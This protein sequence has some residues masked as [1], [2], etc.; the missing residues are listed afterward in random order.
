MLL[1]AACNVTPCSGKA[2]IAAMLQEGRAVHAARAKVELALCEAS[3]VNLE[4]GG[5]GALVARAP[6]REWWGLDELSCVE[7]LEHLDRAP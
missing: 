7:A 2:G 4:H 3:F 6:G 1:S 5:Q